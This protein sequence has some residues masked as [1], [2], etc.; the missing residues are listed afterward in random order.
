M[1]KQNSPGGLGPYLDAGAQRIA[2]ELEAHLVVTLKHTGRHWGAALGQVPPPHQPIGAISF[3]PFRVRDG[4]LL[5]SFVPGTARVQWCRQ[6]QPHTVRACSPH[7]QCWRAQT[8]PCSRNRSKMQ[9]RARG[10]CFGV[11]TVPTVGTEVTKSS[12]PLG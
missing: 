9:Q 11:Q 7:V 6:T 8:R 10:M 5:W 12:A 3:S 1:L 2:A 4:R